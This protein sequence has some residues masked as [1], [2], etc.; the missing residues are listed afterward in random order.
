[1]TEPQFDLERA[2]ASLEAVVGAIG[3]DQ[4]DARTPCGQTLV[5]DQLAHVLGFSEAFRRGATKEGI[6]TSAPPSAAALPDAWRTLIPAQLKALT[7]AW[8]DPAAWA[9]DTEVGGVTAPAPEMARFALNEVIV[10]GWDLAHATGLPYA[11][12]ETDLAVLLDMLKDTPAEG[13]PGLFGPRVPVADDAPPLDRVLGLTGRS[14][15]GLP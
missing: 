9:G 5:R 10:H 3:D 12:A 15:A 13:V 14:T 6:G 11:P 4:L 7:A 8:R 1:M 2:A